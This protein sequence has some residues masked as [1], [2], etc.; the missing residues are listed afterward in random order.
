M[1]SAK[2]DR[3]SPAYREHGLAPLPTL[4]P[5]KRQGDSFHYPQPKGVGAGVGGARAEGVGAVQV[6]PVLVPRS[7]EVTSEGVTESLDGIPIS[8]E[9]SERNSTSG[10]PGEI[11]LD[12]GVYWYVEK[13]HHARRMQNPP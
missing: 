9:V 8:L 11:Q 7:L 13:H 2:P 6:G 10:L 4:H 3:L 1:V 5:P 12:Q